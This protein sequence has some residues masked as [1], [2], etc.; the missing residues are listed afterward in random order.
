MPCGQGG[1]GG[2]HS[3]PG[4]G[5]RREIDACCQRGDLSAAFEAFEAA[6][7]AEEP[8]QTHTCN[9]LLH[10]CSGG[11]TGGG[12]YDGGSGGGGEPSAAKVTIPRPEAVHPERANAVFNY[13][14]T[15][16]VPRT[17][18]TYTALAR[19]EASRGEPRKAFDL[20][21]RLAEE[22][23]TPKLRTFAP[24]LH[25]FCAAGDLDGA[26]EVDDALTAAK[27][28]VT[29]AEYGVLLGAFK[30]AER[31]DDGWA[32]L[33]R[34]RED[35]RTLSD[36]MAAEVRAFLDA[37][38]GWCAAASVTVDESTG[39]CEASPGGRTVQLAA[40]HLS[41]EDR[42]DLLAGIGKLA[43]ERE[44]ADNFDKFVQWLER[45]GP[46]PYLVDGANVGM[47]NQNFQKSQFNFNQVERV[48]AQLRPGAREIHKDRAARF[49]QQAAQQ[50][51]RAAP[52]AEGG[53]ETAEHAAGPAAKNERSEDG[54]GTVPAMQ[55]PAFKPLS[56]K[57]VGAAVPVNFLHVRR[58]RGG[59]ANH[60]K[61]QQCLGNW[62]QA[63]ELFTCPAGSNDDW[64]WLYGAVASGNDSFL[65]SNDEMRDHVF[66]M[67]PAPKLFQRWKE[68]HQ[69][70]FHM[71]AG[72]GLELYF[73]PVFTTCI[74]E[75]GDGS[76]WMFPCDSGEWLCGLRER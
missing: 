41:P 63:G 42:A 40:V 60:H 18:M 4:Q 55:G 12:G 58:T 9:V 49:G 76:W 64:Y 22:R 53:V 5:A 16:D 70:R 47:Y 27:I 2:G 66:Q 33:R 6:V 73:P 59:P 69:V 67:L 62:R 44:A 35:I 28:D 54:G 30:K 17:E 74:Q 61:A 51:A 32:L 72:A 3:K 65:I 7:E 71:S 25:A 37:V 56:T 21:G 31:F 48:M 43:R 24:A 10:M 1:G 36:E 75:A 50:D 45:R 57:A 11:T 39:A 19:I 23:L 20:V 15:S 8:L 14:M 34:V 68:R 26:L 46:L 29:E 52:E 13:M 38:P